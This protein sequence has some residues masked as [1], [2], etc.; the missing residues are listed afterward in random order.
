MRTQIEIGSAGSFD[1]LQ[2]VEEVVAGLLSD[3]TASEALAT[4]TVLQREIEAHAERNATLVPAIEP[5]RPRPNEA[6]RSLALY[7]NHP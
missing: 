3:Q 5:A 6:D 4:L 7:R 2:T 1:G